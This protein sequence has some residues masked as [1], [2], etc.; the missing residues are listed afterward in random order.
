MAGKSAPPNMTSSPSKPRITPKM[1]R[2]IEAAVIAPGRG[3][4]TARL[5]IGAADGHCAAGGTAGGVVSAGGGGGAPSGGS[6]CIGQ[7]STRAV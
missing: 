1:I 6:G 4:T 2:M 3:G 7:E 5:A